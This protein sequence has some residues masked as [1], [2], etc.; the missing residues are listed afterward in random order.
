MSV[1]KCLGGL[2]WCW[3][4]HVLLQSTQCRLSSIGCPGFS[5][6]ASINSHIY[7]CSSINSCKCKRTPTSLLLA[8]TPAMIPFNSCLTSALTLASSSGAPTQPS[9]NKNPKARLMYPTCGTHD[10]GVGYFLDTDCG[11]IS[12]EAAT[13][14]IECVVDV[15]WSVFM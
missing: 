7:W 14:G 8:L 5:T 13:T 9:K 15:Y 4:M 1:N 2:V 10:L 12:S 11:R 3:A 6:G